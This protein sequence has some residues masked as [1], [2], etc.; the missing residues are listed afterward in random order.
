MRRHELVL[1]ALAPG[2]GYRYTPVQVQKLLFLIDRQI[3]EMV[4][5]P[6][7]HFEPYHYGP[8]DSA[9]YQELERLSELG[10]VA[11][12]SSS[13][14]RTFTLTPDGVAAGREALNRAPAGAQDFITRACTFVRAH[15]FSSLVSAIYKAFPEMRVNSVFQS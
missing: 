13:A 5:G 14:L 3:P 1:A 4:E 7:F 10:F 8:F 11:V 2:E 12:D 9:V 15:N 6:H